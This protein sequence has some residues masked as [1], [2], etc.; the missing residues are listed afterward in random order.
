MQLPN[1]LTDVAQL[2]DWLSRPTQAAID[3][4]RQLAGDLLLLGV[5][6]KMGPTLARMARRASEAAGVTRRIIGVSRFS[7]PSLRDQL[8]SWEIETRAGDLLDESFVR[9]LPP[10]ENVLFMTGVK[11]GTQTRPWLTWVMN[12]LAPATTCRSFPAS[13]ILAFSSGNVYGYVPAHSGG[14]K[15]THDLHPVGEYAHSV[16]ARERIFE[17]FSREHGTPVVLLR[18][19]YACELRYGVLVDLA[20]Q[21]MDHS[22]VDVS[23]GHVNV[24]WQGDAN[25]MALA[26]VAD[27]QSPPAI[28]NVAGPETLK[29]RD[30]AARFGQLLDR[31]VTYRG[32]EAADALLSNSAEACRRYG[33][34]EVPVTRLMQ[35]IAD[36]LRRQGEV[37]DKPTHFQNRDGA[38]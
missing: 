27:A 30:L 6:G 1:H 16:L 19:N 11:F 28:L 25:A 36:W 12:T 9:S 32:C 2:E 17:H 26:A 22:P 21:V 5:G 37:W 14:A 8:E 31:P 20:R 3:A 7:Q 38:F 29:I 18:L 33:A 24:I 10:V 23:M 35:W 15:E 13:R 34:P 4:M